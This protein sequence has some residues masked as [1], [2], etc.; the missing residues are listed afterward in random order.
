MKVKWPGMDGKMMTPTF[1]EL[2]TRCLKK[3][4]Q[5]F[6]HTLLTIHHPVVSYKHFKKLITLV[7][8]FLKILVAKKILPKK[9]SSIKKNVVPKK[10]FML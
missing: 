5:F 10:I 9:F 2:Y 6:F 8:G 7:L 3:S 4:G 1:F